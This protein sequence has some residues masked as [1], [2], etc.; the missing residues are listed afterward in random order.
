MPFVAAGRAHKIAAG[1]LT[2]FRLGVTMRTPGS[3]VEL[4]RCLTKGVIA[5]RDMVITVH[6]CRRPHMVVP[7]PTT[8]VNGQVEVPAGGQVKVPAPCGSSVV[9][10]VFSFRCWA[11][12][13]R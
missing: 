9:G 8:C 13:M 6:Y 11:S 12:F 3:G 7:T 1:A 10:Q 4:A 2:A 5:R